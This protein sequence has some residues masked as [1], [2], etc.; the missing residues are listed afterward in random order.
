MKCSLLCAV[1]YLESFNNTVQVQTITFA[2]CM[3]NLQW[4][5]SSTPFYS[6]NLH[7]KHNAQLKICKLHWP[8]CDQVLTDTISSHCRLPMWLYHFK[9]LHFLHILKL[10]LQ[11]RPPVISHLPPS[12]VWNHLRTAL[13]TSAS[14]GKTGGENPSPPHL[15]LISQHHVQWPKQRLQRSRPRCP[16]LLLCAWI[17]RG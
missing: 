17:N 14:A 15:S 12:Q 8:K 1:T 5:G 9:F 7:I 13:E 3:L 2:V 4:T 6:N 10:I 16:S 11:P